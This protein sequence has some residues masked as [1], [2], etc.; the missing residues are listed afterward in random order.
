MS[1][2]ESL[3]WRVFGP[4]KEEIRVVFC[5]RDHF[6]AA[7]GLTKAK[8]GPKVT[9]VQAAGEEL[10]EALKTA[11]VAVPFMERL[12]AT[13]LE[14][15]PR[16][17][18]VMQF[19]VGVEGVDRDAC[20]R[21]GIVLSNIPADESGNAAA[22]AEHALFLILTGLRGGVEY[23]QDGFAGRILGGPAT[24]RQL[25][26]KKVLVVGHGSVGRKLVQLVLAFD[27]EVSV[28][29]GHRAWDLADEIDTRVQGT[30][31]S[32]QLKTG[33]SEKFD[34]V[35]L[36]CP[37][38]WQTRG[39]VDDSFCTRLLRDNGILVN[40]GRGPLVLRSAILNALDTGSL[41][42]FASD[43]GILDDDLSS[44]S[45]SSSSSSDGGAVV[46]PP[47]IVRSRPSEPWDPDDALSRHPRAYFTPHV[48]GYSDGAYDFMS[49]AIADA[50]A[51]IARSEPPVVWLNKPASYFAP[52]F[53]V[54]IQ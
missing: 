39:L 27:A 17:K 49:S 26:K 18:L 10:K 32:D 11:D 3:E 47:K 23:L 12:D 48:G 37:L 22:T 44:S 9:I 5:G 45:G 41:A 53:D 2:R 8:V 25:A 15:A 51:S 29:H 33:T 13:L 1:G 6:R 20:T 35:V 28:A 40:V 42:F 36:G 38:T 43:V 46:S 30:I 34:V 4:V 21:L 14:S 16:L 24:A 54:S 52:L 50:I 31:D 19:G 7:Y